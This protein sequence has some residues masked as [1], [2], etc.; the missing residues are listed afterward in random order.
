MYT[1]IQKQ[2][3]EELGINRLRRIAHLKQHRCQPFTIKKII[4]QNL[5]QRGYDIEHYC[6]Q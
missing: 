6:Q 4:H 5:K 2:Q 1:H 3:R